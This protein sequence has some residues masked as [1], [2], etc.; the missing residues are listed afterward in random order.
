MINYIFKT[1]LV[2]V[3]ALSSVY[4]SAQSLEQAIKFFSEAKYP[5]AAEQLKKMDPQSPRGLGFLCQLYADGYISPNSKEGTEVCNEAVVKR[6]PMGTYIVALA[7]LRGNQNLDFEKNQTLG[8][9]FMSVAVIDYDYAPAYNFFCEKLISEGN[10]EEGINFCKVAASMGMRKSLYQ[11][12]ILT[13]IGRGVIQDFAR[14]KSLM[15]ASAALN[16]SPA[17]IFLGNAAK[18]GLNGESKDLR[19]AYAWYSL[20]AA[21]EPDN[22]TPARLR[23]AL[24]LGASDIVAAQK[25]AKDWKFRNPKLIDYDKSK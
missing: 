2:V 3:V 13:S 6:D 15:L 18:D 1:V 5:Q 16:Y 4:A 23:D 24:S 22:P 10:I 21:A 20:A 12:G 17:Y 25:V 9:G 14:A 11:M 8:V 7:R 19:Q